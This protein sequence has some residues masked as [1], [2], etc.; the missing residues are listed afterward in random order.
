MNCDQLTE[1]QK[2]VIRN[3]E[4]SNVSAFAVAGSGKT[5]V[6][7]CSYLNIID[8]LIRQYGNISKALDR[9]LVITFTDDAATEIK[10]RIREKL[11][12]IY[13][14]VGP[15]NYIS[16]IHGFASKILKNASV[17]MG[18]DPEYRAGE[19]YLLMDI[20]STA[21]RDII[22][23]MDKK[24]IEK[25]TEYLNPVRIGRNEL[26]L[27]DII[28]IL[29]EKTK[30]MGWDIET[31]AEKIRDAAKDYQ[32]ENEAREYLIEPITEIFKQFF[33]NLEKTKKRL[34]ILSYDDILYYAN[35]ALKNDEILKQFKNFDYVIVDEYQD[36]S[37]IQQ[38]I[39]N[40]IADS[41]RQILAGDF[42]QSIYEW[43]DATPMETIKHVKSGNFTVVE[44]NENFRSVPEIIE[45][46]NDIFSKIFAENLPN[47][48]YIRIV[49]VEKHYADG[50][51]FI[52]KGEELNSR[53]RHRAEAE[54]FA[55]SIIYLIKNGKIREGESFRNI[56]MGDIA[57]LF[58]SKSYMKIYADALRKYNI[59]FTFVDK[60]NFFQTEEVNILMDVLEILNENSYE[61]IYYYKVAEIL[62]IVYGWDLQNS[63]DERVK[64]YLDDM[65]ELSK[66][67]N[68][69]K[70]KIILEFLKRTNYDISVLGDSNGIQRYLNIYRFVDLIREIED[71]RILDMDL[72]MDKL[73]GIR[74][75]E[76]ISSLPVSEIK[77]NSVRLMTI[78]ASKGLEFPVVFVADLQSEFRRNSDGMYFDRDLGIY[79]EIEDIMN[80]SSGKKV[81]Q[82]IARK[83]LQENLRIL[84][85]SFTR[86][87][88]FLIFSLPENTSKKEKS[89]SDYILKNLDANKISLYR[90]KGNK[91][92]LEKADYLR[93]SEKSE[94]IKIKTKR[95]KRKLPY[96]SATDV[97]EYLFCPRYYFLAKL[98]GKIFS[99]ESM[100][101]GE[102]FHTF[103]EN[104]DFEEENVPE[105]FSPY[106][107]FLKNTDV[108][109]LFS[110]NKI[111]REY[112][113]KV[114]LE[115]TVLNVR[116]DLLSLGK[117]SVIVDYK[118]GNEDDLDIIQMKIYAFA[119]FKK[120]NKLP[121]RAVIV[122]L[123]NGNVK[124]F[125]FDE[126]DM[127]EIEIMVKDV[128]KSIENEDFHM[129][130]DKCENCNLR[131][132]CKKQN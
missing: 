119:F 67:L 111:Y 77:E 6:L 53:E 26:S 125:K 86:A 18:I 99:N 34:G 114:I 44:M 68:L 70:D 62:L 2:D 50:G 48:N 43:R 42:F 116:Y 87:K 88:Q 92:L 120:F 104:M 39:I 106:I 7:V 31:T 96:I 76:K 132:I 37:Y 55:K 91:I 58:R 1:R 28:F 38:E 74:E 9:V 8:K 101:T 95:E 117:N 115:H 5:S 36:T 4:N 46:V 98:Y 97:R 69:R 130:N 118:T 40:K 93:K 22:N 107:D 123:K 126:N 29:Y 64:K 94:Y 57:I 72:F 16:T 35:I 75:N 129:N 12:S 71:E 84:Y 11:E 54:N 10:E 83:R 82:E 105:I 49:P 103:M 127:R 78:H 90:E 45:F 47:V 121:E 32:D 20:K 81:E 124:E 85:V 65:K 73:E 27:N 30:V 41:S 112:S 33:Q 23:S 56:E 60:E 61:K 14:Y 109:N 131:D 110:D 80:E 17:R 15:L 52:L 108:W 25:I 102:E 51:V 100:K 24:K 79:I 59:K 13:N 89:F 19:E 66:M 63:D 21:Y 122:Y 113:L 128:I 3:I